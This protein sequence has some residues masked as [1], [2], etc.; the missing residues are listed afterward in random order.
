MHRVFNAI[1]EIQTNSNEYSVF[2][3]TE[4]LKLYP[5]D[6]GH[7]SRKMGNDNKEVLRQVIDNDIVNVKPF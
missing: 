2:F 4:G 3:R 5:M 1:I 6:Y 7:I